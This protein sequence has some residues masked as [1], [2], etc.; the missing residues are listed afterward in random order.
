MLG[1]AL[2]P[3]PGRPPQLQP[4]AIVLLMTG[5]ATEFYAQAAPELLRTVTPAPG[6]RSTSDSERPL[7]M[8]VLGLARPNSPLL[9]D[10]WQTNDAPRSLAG[11]TFIGRV[12]LLHLSLTREAAPGA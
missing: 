11:R 7:P 9:P 8:V 3:R 10:D 6:D 1:L 5:G 12:D 4:A 2:G